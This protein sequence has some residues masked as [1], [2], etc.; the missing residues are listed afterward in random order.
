M[1]AFRLALVA[2]HQL[3]VFTLVQALRMTVT[4]QASLLPPHRLVK[5][6]TH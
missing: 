3:V 1:L 6:R 5:G 4:E 2:V